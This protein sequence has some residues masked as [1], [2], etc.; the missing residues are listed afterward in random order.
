MEKRRRVGKNLK[1]RLDTV[2]FPPVAPP[3]MT[4]ARGHERRHWRAVGAERHVPAYRSQNQRPPGLWDH[5]STHGHI[6]PIELLG[7]R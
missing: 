5:S 4:V 7:T 6:Q 2:S 3:M 1:Y